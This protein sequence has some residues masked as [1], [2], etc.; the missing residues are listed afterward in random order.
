[1]PPLSPSQSKKKPSKTM[2]QRMWYR[3]TRG[4]NPLAVFSAVRSRSPR[5]SQSLSASGAAAEAEKALSAAASSARNTGV[6]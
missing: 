5:I 1:M 2:P 6:S 4:S 3:L